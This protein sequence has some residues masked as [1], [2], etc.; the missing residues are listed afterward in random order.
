M[1]RSHIPLSK[2]VMAAQIMSS[3]KKG[4]S[5]LQLQRMISTNYETAWFLFH[6]LRE[7]AD[8][9]RGS[10]PIGGSGKA[11]EVDETYVGGKDKNRHASKK[12]HPRGGTV[13]KMPVVALVERDGTTRSFHVTNVTAATLLP[14]LERHLSRDSH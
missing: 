12:Q 11:V 1:E 7:A 4:F 9:L 6:R 14:I 5:A 2:W 10:G 8:A 13:G 3:S